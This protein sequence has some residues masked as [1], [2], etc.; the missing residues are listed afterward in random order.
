MTRKT[1]G[2]QL[3]VQDILK[4]EFAEPFDKDI[5]LN[6]FRAIERDDRQEWQKRYYQLSDDLSHD[7][8]NN[9]IGKYVKGQTR[10]SNLHVSSAKGK[11]NLITS[12]TEL[13]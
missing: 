2:V 8:V 10:L 6:V 11:S 9:W 3:L 12:Y 1:E 13:G 5:I 7:V 4:S